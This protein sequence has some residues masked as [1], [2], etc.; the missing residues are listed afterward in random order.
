MI[1]KRIVSIKQ[2]I[3]TIESDIKKRIAYN[4]Y[5]KRLDLIPL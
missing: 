5:M 4:E 3:N 1:I 2:D